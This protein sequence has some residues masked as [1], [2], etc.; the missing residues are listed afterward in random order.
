LTAQAPAATSTY[1]DAAV[2]AIAAVRDGQAAA[3]AKATE[4]C[5]QT[6]RADRLIYIFGTGHS[7]MLAEEGFC[8]AGGLACVV[9]IVATSLMLHEGPF[10]SGGI[11]RLEGVAAAVLGRYAIGAGDVLFVFSN[12]GINA[13]PLEAAEF[14]RALGAT[15]IGVSSQAYSR[16][17]A[18]GRRCLADLVDIAIDNGLPPGDALV[19]VGGGVRSGPGSTI[20]GAALLNAILV[21]VAGRLAEAGD[22]PVFISAN[23]PGATEHNAALV[24]RYRARNPHL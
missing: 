7:H 12:S 24:A 1:L 22:A 2:R 14:A 23:M 15:V 8:R 17:A 19:N 11:E 6:A 9:P 13:A 5:F 16:A 3:I 10:V 21:G 4:A 18:K 20:V